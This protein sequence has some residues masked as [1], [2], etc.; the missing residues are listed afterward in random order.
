MS[1]PVHFFQ[2]SVFHDPNARENL[3]VLVGSHLQ[4][5]KDDRDRRV[6][7]PD[8]AARPDPPLRTE[9]RKHLDRRGVIGPHRNGLR[10]QVFR[11][12]TEGSELI[13]IV[14]PPVQPARRLDQF[15]R[16]WP[17]SSAAYA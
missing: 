14:R 1:F 15:P 10:L 17:V 16:R 4:E 6:I 12:Q 7:E 9:V 8:G 13:G 3:G 5:L 11:R 2:R